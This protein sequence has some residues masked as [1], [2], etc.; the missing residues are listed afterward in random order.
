MSEEFSIVDAHVHLWDPGRFT[1]SWLEDSPLLNQPYALREYNAQTAGLPI[2]AMV[3]VEVAVKPDEAL[4]EASSLVELARQ[5]PRLQ[6]I[7]PAVPLEHG[8]AVRGYLENLVSLSPLIKGVRRNL[9]DEPDA[10]MCLQPDFVA[11]VRLLAEFGLSFDICIRHGQLPAIIEL[12][13]LCP[14]TA[15]ILDHCAKPDIRHQL[16]E[17]WQSDLRRLAALPNVVCKV[18][19]LVT[20]ADPL[21]WQPADL[22]PF[23]SIV[24][25]AFGEDRVLFGGDWPV[26]LLASSYRRWYETLHQLT[27]HLPLSAR[28]KL[29]SENA[30]RAYRLG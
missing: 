24:L 26:A 7:V 6:A 12:V 27:A 1:M 16:F 8:T 17:P 23:I 13:R 15:F 11:G 18:S 21:A 14:D 25:E 5:E 3:Y 2:E 4:R 19:G 9:Q 20:E 28:R 22:E 10:R 30:R 29:W